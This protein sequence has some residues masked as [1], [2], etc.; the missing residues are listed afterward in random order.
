MRQVDLAVYADV[1]AGEAAAVAA[2]AERLRSRLRQGAIERRARAELEP[3]TVGRLESLGLLASL[4]DRA[5]KGEL[6]EL[7]Q[8]LGALEELQAWVEGRLAATAA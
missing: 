3:E 4:D 1:L 8:A 7:E 6:R 5:L 2:R